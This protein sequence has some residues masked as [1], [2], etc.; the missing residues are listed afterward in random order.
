MDL[1]MTA[2][3]V[4]FF[5]TWIAVAA[6]LGLMILARLVHAVVNEFLDIKH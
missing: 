6:A 1:L 3:A 5:G 2:I 4:L